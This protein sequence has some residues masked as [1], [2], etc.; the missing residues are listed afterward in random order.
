[1]KQY[2]AEL[3]HVACPEC[4]ETLLVDD[5]SEL[6]QL[7][8]QPVRVGVQLRCDNSRCILRGKRFKPPMTLIEEV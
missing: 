1:M 7:G 4:R 3:H 2:D 6:R 5:V 8:Q